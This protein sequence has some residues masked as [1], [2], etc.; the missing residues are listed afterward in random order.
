MK[1]NMTIVALILSLTALLGT[2]CL[3]EKVLEIVLTA[4]T[5]ADFSQNET[6][7]SWTEPAVVDMGAEIRDILE[8]NGYSTDDLT[9]AH[10]TSASYG[11]TSFSQDHDWQISGEITVTYGATTETVIDYTSESV[12]GLLGDKKSAPLQPAAVDLINQALQD[13]LGGTDPVLT[14]TI[15]NGTT[16]PTPSVEDPM[17]FDWRAWLAIQVIVEESV[18]V[19]DPF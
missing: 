4:E 13:F 18:E 5:S 11:V 7:S 8:D 3:E 12:Q 2:G 9:G 19:P 17:I 16:T 14:F 15:V 6:S 10:M 1:R